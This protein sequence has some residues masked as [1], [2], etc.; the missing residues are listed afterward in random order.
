MFLSD[1]FEPQI[2]CFPILATYPLDLTKTRLQIQGEGNK[3]K[4]NAIETAKTVR[5]RLVFIV[6]CIK[7]GNHCTLLLRRF[8]TEE[9][10]P[11]H[12]ESLKRKVQ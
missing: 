11:L 3:L 7:N 9:W 10:L 6:K 2:I 5:F 12:V 1:K 8:N 4:G